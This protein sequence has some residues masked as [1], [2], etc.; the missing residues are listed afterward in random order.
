MIVLFLDIDGVLA[1]LAWMRSI[2]ALWDC[3]PIEQVDPVPCARL[4]RVLRRTGALIVVSSSWRCDAN[5]PPLVIESILRSR[6]AP[7]AVV[8]GSTPDP[9]TGS[10][11]GHE[12]Q[13]WLDAHPEVTR[14]AIVDDEGGML[15]LT[16][17]LVKTTLEHGLLDEHVERLVDMLGERE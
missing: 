5:T 6:G 8:I 7:S 14:F 10:L 4:E 12:I 2:G 16:P 11:R 13:R 9:W 17:R 15:H 1:T 3:D